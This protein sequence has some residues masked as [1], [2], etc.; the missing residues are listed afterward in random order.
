M[1]ADLVIFDCDGVL[2]DTEPIAVRVSVG[3][4]AELGWA[5]TE[6]EV[7]ELF[8]GRS[9][10]SISGV[11]A[12]RV[13]MAGAAE[14]ERR[15]VER[16]TAAMS[17]ELT[18][19]AGIEEAL[20]T[21]DAA[22]LP[23]C[24]ASSGTHEKMRHTLGHTGLYDRFAGRIFSATE[25]VNGK[26]APDLFLHAASS[27]GVRPETAVVV[28]DSRYGIQAARAA[29]IALLRLRGRRHPHH[30]AGRRLH[31]HRPPHARPTGLDH[32]APR[33]RGTPDLG[34]PRSNRPKTPRHTAYRAATA[35]WAGE[36]SPVDNLAEWVP[37]VDNFGALGLQLRT[38]RPSGDKHPV[39]GWGRSEQPPIYSLPG[40]GGGVD[41]QRSLLWTEWG[42][43]LVGFLAGV[44]G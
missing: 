36:K 42:L 12:E 25:V 34:R 21:L 24:V 44:G 26:P 10:A 30:L 5:I 16:H 3:V 41:P 20:D 22:G 8:V 17:A 1:R 6:A 4:G 14:W 29:G 27:M 32:P 23:Y 28:E 18:A 31:H 39:D 19:V 40:D 15:F 13:G 35:V 33:R 37:S 7:V 43:E 2:V 38:A 9:A 11:I